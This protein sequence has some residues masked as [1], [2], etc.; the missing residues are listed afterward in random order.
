MYLRTL[1]GSYIGG[2]AMA[3]AQ[4]VPPD[5]PP[6]IDGAYLRALV[7]TAVA[8]MLGGLALAVWRPSSSPW[9]TVRVTVLGLIVGAFAGA[10]MLDYP[11][12]FPADVQHWK[13]GAR[14]MVA[15]LV[16]MGA[17]WLIGALVRMFTAFE[18]NP[19][20]YIKR[21]LKEWASKP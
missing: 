18:S 4:A 21:A 15:L 9:V 8:G 20:L 13:W 5:L 17:K 2:W 16:G 1:F 7:P 14:M 12:T 11:F 3:I 19:L 6:M 10:F